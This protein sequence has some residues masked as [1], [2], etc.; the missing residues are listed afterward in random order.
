MDLKTK[1]ACQ[2]PG[3]D[4]GDAI[5]KGNTI[6]HNGVHNNIRQI[7][8]DSSS[9]AEMRLQHTKRL[10]SMLRKLG[11]SLEKELSMQK[12]ELRRSKRQKRGK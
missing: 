11:T 1:H 4:I 10:L 12:K 2:M 6:R 5:H 9:I 8:E 7:R 3:K